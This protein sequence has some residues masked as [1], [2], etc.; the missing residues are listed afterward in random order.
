MKKI[1]NLK[2]NVIS[3]KTPIKSTNINYVSKKKEVKSKDC[4]IEWI[5]KEI[6]EVQGVLDNITIKY[7]NLVSFAKKNEGKWLFKKLEQEGR[8]FLRINSFD[9]NYV[10]VEKVLIGKKSHTYTFEYKPFISIVEDINGMK[11]AAVLDI[12]S[13]PE[14]LKKYFGRCN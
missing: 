5:P 6:K 7:M 9:K 3:K 8:V 14:G 1:I 2:S 12:K 10:S 13:I 4:E 11:L